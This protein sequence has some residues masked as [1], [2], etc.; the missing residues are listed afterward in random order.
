MKPADILMAISVAVIWGMGVVFAKAAIEHFPPI[1]LMAL[2]FTLIAWVAMWAAPQ[3]FVASWLVEDGQMQA[4]ES[5]PPIV[6]VAIV[7]L[8]LVMTAL[9]YAIRQEDLNSRMLVLTHLRRRRTD[10]R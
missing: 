7:Y 10:L 1:L 6:W 4:M 8:G 9:G 5:A 3:L 2:R